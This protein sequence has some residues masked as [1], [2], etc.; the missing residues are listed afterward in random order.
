MTEKISENRGGV[1]LL[2]LAKLFY[3][4]Y[5]ILKP[6]YI[7]ASGTVQMAE[8]CMVIAGVLYATGRCGRVKLHV[9]EMRYFY[10]FV[11]GV[12]GINTVYALMLQSI[13][14]L[15]ATAY[16]IFNMLFLNLS[17]EMLS[18]KEILKRIIFW[19]IFCL[20]ASIYTQL[21][22][23]IFHF[24]EWY[25]PYE[26]YQGSFN[27]P[28][29]FGFYMFACAA[30]I[31]MHE[32]YANKITVNGCVCIATALFLIV[33]SAS[34][35]ETLG[36]V[37][38]ILLELLNGCCIVCKNYKRINIKWLCY[39]II[40]GT[41]II[42]VF[43]F[44]TMSFRD[45]FD[46]ISVV[47]RW[48]ETVQS[49]GEGKGL[50][51]NGKDAFA[52]RAIDRVWKYPEYL[53]LGAGEGGY[54]RFKGLWDGEM[55]STFPGILFCYGFFPF[56]TVGMWCFQRIRGL[57]GKYLAIYLA[58]LIESCVIVN[59]RQPIFW[60]LFVMGEFIQMK[61]P[62]GNKNLKLRLYKGRKAW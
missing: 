55:H 33:K 5:F 58:V 57:S 47:V 34:R 42:A 41:V 16:W 52:E 31:L 17:Y 53:L 18:D 44:V 15:T 43:F 56:L 8:V 30:V 46:N 36:V 13:G 14:F 50:T 37:M 12:T 2:S 38:V 20:K 59:Y 45:S 27:D 23:Y 21:F 61:E 49:V 9:R 28:N 25:V 40:G 7:R 1:C 51:S 3:C 4:F 35:A 19:I 11:I 54:G 29:Q 26:R 10:L 32:M 48:R 6:F 62:G 60:L 22:L 24:G 39:S